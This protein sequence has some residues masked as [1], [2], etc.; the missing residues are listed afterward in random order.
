MVLVPSIQQNFFC[1]LRLQLLNCDC[2]VIFTKQQFSFTG[3]FKA[4]NF[5]EKNER[6]LVTGGGSF[7]LSIFSLKKIVFFRP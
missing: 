5:L 3:I 7:F 2:L 6:A 4:K 1:P